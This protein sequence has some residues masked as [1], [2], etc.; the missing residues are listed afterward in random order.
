MRP[1]W[2]LRHRA[3]KARAGFAAAGTAGCAISTRSAPA[4][5][6]SLASSCDNRMAAFETLPAIFPGQMAP[7]I[8]Q[9]TD[10]ERELVMR[11]C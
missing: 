4:A 5:R 3:A 7:V 6:R 10:G 9:S 8:E 1:T 11:S 2:T